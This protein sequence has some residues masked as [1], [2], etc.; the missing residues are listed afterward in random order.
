MHEVVHPVVEA[1]RLRRRSEQG[2]PSRWWQKPDRVHHGLTGH[3]SKPVRCWYSSAS[4]S[5]RA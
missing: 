1:L 2:L 4:I 5:P 3:G